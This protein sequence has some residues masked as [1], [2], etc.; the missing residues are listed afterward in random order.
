MAALRAAAQAAIAEWRHA[1][2]AEARAVL[3]AFNRR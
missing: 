1:A 3:D 2:G